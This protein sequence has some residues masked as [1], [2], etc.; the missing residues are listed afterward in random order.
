MCATT[1]AGGN[2]WLLAGPS[3]YKKPTK[4]RVVSYFFLKITKCVRVFHVV[5]QLRHWQTVVLEI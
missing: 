5:A 2:Y 4:G 1:V 3:F